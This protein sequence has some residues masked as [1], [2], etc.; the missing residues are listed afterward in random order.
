MGVKMKKKVSIIVP[1][2]NSEEYIDRCIKSI[3][4]QTYDRF[5]LI[6]IDDGST[7]RSKEIC[8]N[9]K[10]IDKRIMAI[11]QKNG[12]AGLARNVGLQHATGD[13]LLFVDSDDWIDVDLLENVVKKIEYY[14]AE[15]VVFGWKCEG[16]G[17]EKAYQIVQT[18]TI[19]S[20]KAIIEKIIDD[21]HVYGGGYT[22]NK[23]WD[24]K[25][26]RENNSL[27]EKSLFLYEDKVFAISNYIHL[28]RVLLIP[29]VYYHYVERDESLSHYKTFQWNVADNVLLAQKKMAELLK[30]IPDLHEIAVKQYYIST[31][32]FLGSAIKR[33]NRKRIYMYYNILLNNLAFILKCSSI[34]IVKRIKYSLFFLYAQCVSHHV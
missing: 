17:K 5:E 23:L 4:Q 2:Y 30:Y 25:K 13:Y 33:Q 10:K 18:D 27:F 24:M 29:D 7:D 15:A 20:G 19:L 22:V 28:N 14:H 31:M 6:L 11:S 21:D 16:R 3:L 32:E 8:Q 26:I 1:I 34:P 12:G 9:Y